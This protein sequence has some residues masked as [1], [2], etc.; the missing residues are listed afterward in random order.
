MTPTAG[1]DLAS[2]LR[3]RDQNRATRPTFYRLS[4]PADRDAL[5]ALLAA[6]PAI[7]IH[8]QLQS[9]LAELLKN[10]HPDRRH[11]A[12]E[13]AA[14]AERHR[15]DTP[16]NEY[17]TWV[18][19][20]WSRQLVHL[21]DRAEF[22]ELRTCRNVYKITPEERDFLATRRYGVIGL[23]VGQAIAFTLAM[24]RGCGELRLADFDTLE[25]SNLN[26]LRAGV[27]ELGLPK[28]VIAARA[29]AE[30]DPYLPVRCFLDGATAANLDAFLLDGG[31]LDILIEECDGIDVKFLARYRARAHGIPVVMETS[32]RGMIDIERFDREP[33]R[34]IFHGLVPETAPEQLASLTPP[35]KA[36]IV[37]PLVQFEKLSPR[38]Q[39]SMGEI[40]RTIGNWPQLASAIAL[41]GAL[42]TDTCRRMSLG[43]LR[44]SGRYYADLAALITD[45]TALFTDAV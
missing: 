25:L 30:I 19:Y 37:A 20:P 15:G 1:P 11:T 2:R 40:G 41:G 45:E 35:E 28:V 9:Q 8:D 10:R 24:E 42:V 5:G 17:G 44:R 21:L 33:A 43:E 36:A 32:D 6:D 4:D 38:L 22:V 16:S 12:A 29:I 18:H 39:R 31:K 23:S 3:P 27:H 26:R 14:A 7:T 13:L 34:P